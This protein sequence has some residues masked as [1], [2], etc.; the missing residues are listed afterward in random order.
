MTA[1]DENDMQVALELL[2]SKSGEWAALEYAEKVVLLEGMLSRFE[3][4]DHVEWSKLAVAR[5]GYALGP[6]VTETFAAVE[7]IVSVSIIAERIRTMIRTY[8]HLAAHGVPPQPES[9][10]IG[11][12]LSKSLVF[13]FDSAERKGRTGQAGVKVEVHSRPGEGGELQGKPN[14]EPGLCLV[15]GAGNQ[16]SLAF[17]DVLYWLFVEGKVAH[18]LRPSPTHT[19]VGS[20]TPPTPALYA[21]PLPSPPLR[22]PTNTARTPPNP[23]LDASHPP[24]PCRSSS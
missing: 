3:A 16:S 14:Q 10:D 24:S 6:G 4:I 11:G 1:A 5:Q 2:H 19:F 8:R 9:R 17:S 7:Q 12:G 23:A 20:S 21:P 13:P 18:I 15:L 22:P